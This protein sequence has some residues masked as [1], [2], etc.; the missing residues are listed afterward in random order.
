MLQ[1][2][3][4]EDRLLIDKNISEGLA[5]LPQLLDG[6]MDQAMMKIHAKPPRPK[7]VPKPEALMDL[8]PKTPEA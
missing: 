4:L 7:P 5:A 8:P 1:K 6:A 3:R 2:P